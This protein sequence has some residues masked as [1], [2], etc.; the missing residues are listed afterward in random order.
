MQFGTSYWF[1]SDTDYQSLVIACQAA[2]APYAMAAFGTAHQVTSGSYAGWY[3]DV[4]EIDT[5]EMEWLEQY[6]SFGMRTVNL[7]IQA[8]WN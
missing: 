7:S 2:N 1:L 4:G 6:E 8:G 5:D 3:F